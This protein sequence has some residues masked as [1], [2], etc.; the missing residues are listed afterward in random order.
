MSVFPTWNSEKWKLGVRL[1]P[2]SGG[3]S[4]QHLGG[5]IRWI[6]NPGL[7]KFGGS[8]AELDCLQSGKALLLY[9]H[10]NARIKRKFIPI[11]R[12]EHNSIDVL[13]R[14]WAFRNRCISRQTWR[15]WSNRRWGIYDSFGSCIL[16]SGGDS[17]RLW[18][19][20]SAS[21]RICATVQSYTINSS[22]SLSLISR[23]RNE[24]AAVLIKLAILF[25]FTPS[26]LVWP[27]FRFWLLLVNQLLYTCDSFMEMS[28]KYHY[29]L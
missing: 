8:R 28:Y 5:K 24:I 6:A 21:A 17:M 22:F 10:A 27:S 3:K 18:L 15:K 23:A 2:K 19:I 26:A 13:S 29:N 12:R 16:K 4:I 1:C 14:R 9:V 7:K 11:Y 25:F 20:I